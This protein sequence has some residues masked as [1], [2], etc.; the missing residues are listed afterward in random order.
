MF[1]LNFNGISNQ[2]ILLIY[3]PIPLW[4]LSICTHLMIM[5]NLLYTPK[6][7]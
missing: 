2:F 4:D 6:K 5:N 3:I 1:V 7:F